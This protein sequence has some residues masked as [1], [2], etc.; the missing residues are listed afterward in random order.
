M[1]GHLYIFRA[2]SQTEKCSSATS[3]TSTQFSA[4]G[5]WVWSVTQTASGAVPVI[6]LRPAS[7]GCREYDVKLVKVRRVL[8]TITSMLQALTAVTVDGA[9]VDECITW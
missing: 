8:W 6:H 5:T 3:C 2:P 4:R 7:R 1:C 9:T